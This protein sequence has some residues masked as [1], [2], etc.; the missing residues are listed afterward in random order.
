MYYLITAQPINVPQSVK[1]PDKQNL[2]NYETIN[3]F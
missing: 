1:Q 2:I 3:Y